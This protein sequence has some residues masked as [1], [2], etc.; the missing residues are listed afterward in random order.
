MYHSVLWLE[1]AVSI[2]HRENLAAT[3]PTLFYAL[4][5][6]V[7]PTDKFIVLCPFELVY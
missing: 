6:I 7:F 1:K 3:W 4:T 5:V 2:L